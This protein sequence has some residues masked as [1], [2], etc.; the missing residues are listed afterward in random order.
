MKIA[1]SEN[2]ADRDG[3][4]TAY[5]EDVDFLIARAGNSRFL[6]ASDKAEAPYRRQIARGK[7]A[8]EKQIEIQCR[9]MAEGIL[10]G[11]RGPIEGDDGNPLEYSVDNAYLM[12]R[13]NADIRDF[14]FEAATEQERYR[15]EARETTA[16]KSRTTSAG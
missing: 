16:K 6:K 9:A 8:T 12:L 11:W 5:T 15:V 10:L 4:W 2:P 13:Y 3:L 7:L 1:T 14:V